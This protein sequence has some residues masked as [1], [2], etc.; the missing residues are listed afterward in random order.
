VRGRVSK[1]GRFPNYESLVQS[2]H[3][4]S[5]GTWQCL[6]VFAANGAQI[7][8]TIDHSIEEGGIKPEMWPI[9]TPIVFGRC[10]F[11]YLLLSFESMWFSKTECSAEKRQSSI[12]PVPRREHKCLNTSAKCGYQMRKRQQNA[13]IECCQT[14]RIYR[15]C[16]R[17][18]EHRSEFEITATWLSLMPRNPWR[19]FSLDLAKDVKGTP[20]LYFA[21]QSKSLDRNHPVPMHR[22][23]PRASDNE[24]RCM[25]TINTLGW[26]GIMLCGNESVQAGFKLIQWSL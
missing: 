13:L 17:K 22:S 12:S 15:V 5:D 20:R 19:K 9:K 26:I 16:S 10:A 4:E 1:K 11:P 23:H 6:L 21:N 18:P 7:E 2:E 8:F 25:K 3:S 14:G 24:S